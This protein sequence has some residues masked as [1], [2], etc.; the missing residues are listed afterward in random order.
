MN[1]LKTIPL[2][3][4]QDDASLQ[5]I[6]GCLKEVEYAA[7]K[8]IIVEGDEGNNFYMIRSG[9]VKCTKGGEE[10]SARL[11]KGDFFGELALLSSDKRQATVTSTQPTS[12]LMLGR[13]EFVRLIGPLDSEIK[14][15]AGQKRI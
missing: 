12:V 13:Q 15:L 5:T 2:L 11:G 7:D 9:E 6:A 8:N 1:V 14:E 4:K 3:Q 10:V